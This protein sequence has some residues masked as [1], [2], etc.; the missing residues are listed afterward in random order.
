V[1]FG[2]YNISEKPYGS[3][4]IH[5]F[6][7]VKS[8][9]KVRPG[10]VVAFITSRYTM[11]RVDEGTRRL[12]SRPLIWSAP[13]AC[14]AARRA[15]SPATPAPKSPPTSS[16]CAKRSRAKKPFP[17]RLGDLKEI[18]TPDGPVSINEY[19]ADNPEMMLGEMRLA[20]THVP[21]RR[22]GADR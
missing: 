13:S 14:R 11:D 9:D 18:Q 10:G 3:F 22:A 17:A 19:F 2:D 15:R 7:F 8:L 20:G 12:L 1:P 4:P 5:D 16:S 6:F 21:R